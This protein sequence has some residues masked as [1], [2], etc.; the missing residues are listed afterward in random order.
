MTIGLN[1]TFRKVISASKPV[2]K[3]FGGER[4]VTYRQR[5]GQ[6]AGISPSPLIQ[7]ADGK[8]CVLIG[9]GSPVEAAADQ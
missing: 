3:S 2:L 9:V 1:F 5:L 8:R 7:A 6:R 4:R